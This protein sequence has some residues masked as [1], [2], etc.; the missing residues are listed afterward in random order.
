M[1]KHGSSHCSLI[2]RPSHRCSGSGPSR[3]WRSACH[4]GSYLQSQP[5]TREKHACWSGRVWPAWWAGC[6]CWWCSCCSWGVWT[7]AGSDIISMP[8]KQVGTVKH[9]A[10]A[11]LSHLSD[12]HHLDVLLIGGAVMFSEDHAVGRP[13]HITQWHHFLST[14][15]QWSAGESR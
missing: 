14:T 13:A 8:C 12:R 3:M 2:G 11:G 10:A 6:R 9:L 15:S 1:E 7:P 5:H 4:Q